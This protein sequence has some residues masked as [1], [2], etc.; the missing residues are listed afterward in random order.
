VWQIVENGSR[1]KKGKRKRIIYKEEEK[2]ET[3]T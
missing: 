3:Y 2:G 1:K